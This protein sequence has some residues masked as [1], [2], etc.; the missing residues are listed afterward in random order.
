M[1]MWNV[2]VHDA[3]LNSSRLYVVQAIEVMF[4]RISLVCTLEEFRYD[5]LEGRRDLRSF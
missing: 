2:E 1:W 3:Q 4:S 5:E